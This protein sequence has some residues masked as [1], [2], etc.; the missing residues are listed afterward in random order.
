MNE[1]LGESFSEAE[2]AVL[3][4]R[5]KTYVAREEKAIGADSP[6]NSHILCSQV[7]DSKWRPATTAKD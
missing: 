7:L 4:G 6:R 3:V 5:K 2:R 1:R